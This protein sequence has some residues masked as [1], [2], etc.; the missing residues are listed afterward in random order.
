M[1][2]IEVHCILDRRLLIFQ[3]SFDK[4][5]KIHQLPRSS[6]LSFEGYAESHTL[7]N[8]TEVLIGCCHGFYSTPSSIQSQDES[9]STEFLNVVQYTKAKTA[10]ISYWISNMENCKQ[11]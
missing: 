3:R 4:E 10:K 6:Y 2:S 5:C 8:K 7:T 1:Q 11:F 9:L